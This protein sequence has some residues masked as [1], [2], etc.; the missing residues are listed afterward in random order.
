MYARPQGA[1]TR[2]RLHR[3]KPASDT[4]LSVSARVE[5]VAEKLFLPFTSSLDELKLPPVSNGL[6]GAEATLPRHSTISEFFRNL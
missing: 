2:C 1:V 3:L 5:E 6:R 4:N